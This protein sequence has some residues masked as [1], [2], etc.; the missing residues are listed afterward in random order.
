M[1]IEVGLFV[2]GIKLLCSSSLLCY[3]SP[4]SHLPRA[5]SKGYKPD[6]I[7][8]CLEEYES[9]D[10]WQLNQARTKLTMANL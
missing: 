6:A 9:L 10:V 7:D 2:S 8:R 5:T 4:D 3:C 1:H